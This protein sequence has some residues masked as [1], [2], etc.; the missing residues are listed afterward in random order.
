MVCYLYF[1]PVKQNLW[2]GVGEGYKGVTA[3]MSL[4]S[5]PPVTFSE[6]KQMTPGPASSQAS[7]R[8]A[9]GAQGSSALSADPRPGRRG[10]RHLEVMHPVQPTPAARLRATQT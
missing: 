9:A 7:H 6:L 3:P 4:E 1:T 10:E 2:M 8:P 5:T